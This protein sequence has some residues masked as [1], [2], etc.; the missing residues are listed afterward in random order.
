MIA[1]V[2][3]I[4]GALLIFV[5]LFDVFLT[6]LYVRIGV[7]GASRFG[8]GIISSGIAQLSWLSLLQ[9]S[10]VSGGKP[11]TVLSFCGPTLGLGSSMDQ[12]RL[13]PLLAKQTS[14]R[15]DQLMTGRYH[16]Y[17]GHTGD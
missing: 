17:L 15:S 13:K 7:A 12:R 14:A 8:T 9:L 5:A 4:L 3:Q 16:V 1:L 11:D 6:V 2:E 10:R